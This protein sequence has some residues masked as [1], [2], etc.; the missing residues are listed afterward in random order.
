MWGLRHSLPFLDA[1]THIVG[2]VNVIFK[3][4][5]RRSRRWWKAE[6]GRASER[7]GES[8]NKKESFLINDT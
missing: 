2:V 6:C 1:E 8:R 3:G 5:N 4:N 7:E